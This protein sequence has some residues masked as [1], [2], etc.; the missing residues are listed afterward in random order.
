VNSFTDF[1]LSV[2]TTIHACDK[3]R[4]ARFLVSTFFCA[5]MQLS[6]RKSLLS[7]VRVE[8]QLVPNEQRGTREKLRLWISI[9]EK[10]LIKDNDEVK[11][12]HD[13]GRCTCWFARR[14][15]RN[16]PGIEPTPRLRSSFSAQDQS[17]DQK[18]DQKVKEKHA[19]KGQ[20]SCKGKGG[21]KAS[22][23]GCKGKNSCKGK[24][25]C[26]TDGSKPPANN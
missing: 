4:F 11:E 19:C 2:G 9:F 17:Q 7:P 13:G 5:F 3:S 15:Y 22:D 21:C 8:R 26:A 12:S 1:D 23:N 6:H 16:H 24:G 14:H 25:G 10:E 18:A 20:N